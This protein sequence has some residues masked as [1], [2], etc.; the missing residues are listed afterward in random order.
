MSEGDLST[1]GLG[2][3]R[4]E[5]LSDGIFAT[6]MTVLVLSLSVP[7]ISGASRSS[8][9]MT[10]LVS[11]LPN[12][13]GYIDSFV[14]IG[15]YWVG[16]HALFH[17]VRRTNRPLLWLNMMFLLSV[18]FI[19]FSTALIG[20][21]PFLQIPVMIYGGNLIAAGLALYTTSWYC[22]KNRRMVDKDL[23]EHVVKLG[24]RRILVGP[25]V[26]VVAILLSYVDTRISLALYAI[27]P[28]YYILPGKIDVHL[29]R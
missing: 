21:Y 29:S 14:V 4:I 23:S 27:T 3:N 24:A 6:V 15:V 22:M 12:I 5:A 9:L 25:L 10:D 26:Y 13:A 20:R 28:I 8:E 17:F 19:P 11:L 2:K 18:G 16:H 7:V 1:A